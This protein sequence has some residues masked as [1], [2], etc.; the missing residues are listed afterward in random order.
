MNQ[1][2]A[3]KLASEHLDSAVIGGNLLAL[4]IADIIGTVRAL[5]EAVTAL[6]K[7]VDS[8]GIGIAIVYGDK[9]IAHLSGETDVETRTEGTSHGLYL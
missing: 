3:R 7:K 6:N 5:E 1:D 9:I 2:E 4:P 8:I